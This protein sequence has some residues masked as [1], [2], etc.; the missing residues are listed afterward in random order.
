V[1]AQGTRK[2]RLQCLIGKSFD[3]VVTPN[4]VSSPDIKGVKRPAIVDVKD[5]CN[6]FDLSLSTGCNVDQ[7]PPSIRQSLQAGLSSRRVWRATVLS[8]QINGRC[9]VHLPV[10]PEDG[11][12]RQDVLAFLPAKQVSFGAVGSDEAEK[13]LPG[14]EVDVILMRDIS[15]GNE[16]PSSL[17]VSK[18]YALLRLSILQRQLVEENCGVVVNSTIVAVSTRT[19]VVQ[20]ALRSYAGD[21]ETITATLHGE[22]L[23]RRPVKDIV[24]A[25][26]IGDVLPVAVVGVHAGSGVCMVNAK[27]V[28]PAMGYVPDDILE[29]LKVLA[30][31]RQPV[32]ATVSWVL[33][34]GIAMCTFDVSSADNS[35]TTAVLTLCDPPEESAGNAE[36]EKDNTASFFRIG[37]KV[38][39]WLSYV[40]EA[41]GK[42]K[43][44]LLRVLSSDSDEGGDAPSQS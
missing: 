25:Y 29:E 6:Y 27:L 5:R 13:L 24:A 33:S 19:V 35:R 8:T 11:S 39:L 21:V 30:A 22:A 14:D 3:V 43:G 12:E 9:V 16:L 41:G 36:G 10:D 4:M 1:G 28:E 44:R 31:F 2:E 32:Q 34:N 40:N 7:L 18:R 26:H 38:E 23:S 17:V 15:G 42:V 37:D 20:F